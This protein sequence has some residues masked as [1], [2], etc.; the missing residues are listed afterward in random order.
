MDQHAKFV[1]E[2]DQII[3]RLRQHCLCETSSLAL[4]SD[5][6]LSSTGFD[7]LRDQLPHFSRL[8]YTLLKHLQCQELRP[9]ASIV[10]IKECLLMLFKDGAVLELE[11]LADLL[12]FISGFESI[13]LFLQNLPAASEDRSFV[14]FEQEIEFLLDFLR[15]LPDLRELSRFM[16]RYIDEQ[17]FLKEDQIPELKAARLHII[18]RKAELTKGAQS[19][20]SQNQ[21][22]ISG[23]FATTR[24]GRMVIPLK[25][26]F[27]GRLPGLV[28]QSSSSG[29][30]LYLEPFEMVEKNNAVSQAE[31]EYQQEVLR[32]VRM[33]SARCVA[34][35]VALQSAHHAVQTFDNYFCRASFARD[36]QGSLIGIGQHVC[37]LEARHPLLGK[38][39]V[40]I[41]LVF[42]SDK[43]L[44]VVSGP[45][46][47][48]KT[49]ALK[50][51][52]LFCLMNQAGLLLPCSQESSIPIFDNVFADIG[53]EQS[54]SAS[55][56]TFSGHLAQIAHIIRQAQHGSLILIDE[57][58]SG[59]DP[60]EGAALAMAVVERLLDTKPTMMVTSH[61]SAIKALAM[62]NPM[63]SNASM[64]FSETEH[65]PTYRV[66]AGLPGQSHALD[67]AQNLGFE[68]TV[69]ARARDLYGKKESALDQL[70]SS[71]Q[72]QVAAAR[73]LHI[74]NQD[75]AAELRLGIEASQ[76]KEK[77]LQQR[78]LE[79]QTLQQ[80]QAGEFLKQSRSSVEKL[81]RELSDLKSSLL[82]EQHR[83][84][85]EEQSKKIR[86]ELLQLSNIEE[87]KRQELELKRT[88]QRSNL[89][90][91]PT[92]GDTVV[93]LT[94]GPQGTLERLNKDGSWQASFK[95]KLMKLSL[96]TFE[97]VHE[98][99]SKTKPKISFSYDQSM[100]AQL[101]IDV[102]GMRMGEAND[103]VIKQLDAAHVQ[104][105][106]FFYIIH[107]KGEGILQTSIRAILSQSALVQKLEFALPQDGG[108]GKTIVYL[109]R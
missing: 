46:T 33:I 2:F 90:R 8:V 50:S 37:L 63:A 59:T 101:Q 97:L 18:S 64:A 26:D 92:L 75:R 73:E 25:A 54:I 17:G 30:T 39:A 107:G 4:E 78:D 98:Q 38:K 88:L 47:G 66:I 34:D 23:D 84:E 32:I 43:R 40:P 58:G 95:G 55:L 70:M 106:E 15:D 42:P 28:H 52:G 11:Q 24:D 105:T 22:I 21:T 56:S 41:D 20:I 10:D 71:M 68:T 81:L 12:S 96:G 5:F 76:R 72:E 80:H 109:K 74:R 85:V 93:L 69:I 29:A 45:N 77:E 83:Q 57:L 27:K 53:D 36:Y 13:K 6:V 82:S 31:N 100:P 65:K 89:A 87:H 48:G 103:H 62:S 7:V 51:L 91:V 16:R 79:L 1:L 108:T 99:A 35:K 67:I 60:D 49:V 94:G 14:G 61:H 44:L 9:H 86:Q 102:R 19:I 3:S 104:G